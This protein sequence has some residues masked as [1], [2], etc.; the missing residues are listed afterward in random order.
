MKHD[1]DND[2]LCEHVV[3]VEWLAIVPKEKAF[4][5]KGLKKQ[6]KIVRI[7]SEVNIQLKK[8]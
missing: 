2:E 5:T 1:L 4:W 7:N 6:T 8:F 3:R